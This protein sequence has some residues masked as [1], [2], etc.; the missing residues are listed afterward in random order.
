MRS[1]ALVQ[2]L[3]DVV[4]NHNLWTERHLST[5]LKMPLQFKQVE[6]SDSAMKGGSLV[7]N[8]FANTIQNKTGQ[9]DYKSQFRSFTFMKEK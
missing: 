9:F 3:K 4:K 7:F 8:K 2:T 5:V 1:T 6:I